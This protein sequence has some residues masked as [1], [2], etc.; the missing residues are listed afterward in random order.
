MSRNTAL[1]NAALL[2]V[3]TG[4]PLAAQV[5]SRPT[6]PPLVTAANESWYQMGEPIQFADDL[7]YRAGATVFFDGN[8]MVRSGYYNGVPLYTDT[9]VEPYS[10]ILVPLRSGLMQPYERLRRGDLAGSTGSRTPSFPVSLMADRQSYRQAIAAPTRLPQTIG[11]IPSSELTT[12]ARPVPT[13]IETIGFPRSEAERVVRTE[14][15]GMA[16]IIRPENNDGVWIHYQ[17]TKWVSA[18]HAVPLQSTEFRMSGTYDG[19]PVFV[20]NSDSDT[21]TVYLPTRA[22]LVAPYRQR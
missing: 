7:Y 18:G 20:R 13:S 3:L 15:S 16:S 11:A 9:T 5:Q 2:I 17:G 22:G 8:I 12:P 21:K 10:L 4:T 19:F 14:R 6:D 1:W